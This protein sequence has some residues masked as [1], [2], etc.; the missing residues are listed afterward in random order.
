MS[1]VGPL[2]LRD[3]QA[4][5]NLTADKSLYHWN[6]AVRSDISWTICGAGHFAD[7]LT[8]RSAGAAFQSLVQPRI[9]CGR[10]G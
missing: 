6:S 9:R 10:E 1:I 3:V 2:V 5:N 4:E 7:G 8:M